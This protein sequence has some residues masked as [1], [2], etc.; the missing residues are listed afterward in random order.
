MT[1]AERE[2]A[3]RGILENE[4]LPLAKAKSHDYGGEDVWGNLRKG[5]WQGIVMRMCD[6]ADRLFNITFYEEAQ[7]NDESIEDTC[8][9]LV[10]YAMF[11]LIMKRM[12]DSSEEEL[13][14]I[15]KAFF[16]KYSR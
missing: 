15:E 5:N 12:D 10:N 4:C 9:D 16:K 13:K 7:V 3:M 1:L 6:K 14:E 2:A 8:I 11:I